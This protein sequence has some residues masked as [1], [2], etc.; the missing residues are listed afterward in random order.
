MS[1]VIKLKGTFDN[2]N[3][4]VL[5]SEGLKSGFYGKYIN[6]LAT[7]DYTLTADQKTAVEAFVDYLA[8]ND[9]FSH[10]QTIFP[11][12]GSSTNVD[13][14]KVPLVGDVELNFADSF[15]SFSFDNDN[16]IVGLT[17][18]PAVTS[19]KLAD[20][21]PK[22]DFLGVAF[23][24]NKIATTESYTDRLMN[25][26]TNFQVR[27]QADK[28]QVYVRTSSGLTTLVGSDAIDGEVKAAAGSF[29]GLLAVGGGKYV[30]YA[31][32]S[33]SVSY[34]GGNYGYTVA[35]TSTD[36]AKSLSSTTSYDV[37]GVFT[38]ITFFKDMITK[39]QAKLYMDGLKAFMTALGRNV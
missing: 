2:P 32:K 24:T 28:I 22:E 37:A 35:K 38:S 7:H 15:D 13:A 10:I 34:S 26:D 11:F 21:Q 39:E 36:L 31:S 25:F 17:G 30:R 29:Y 20:V 18:T 33:T 6:A 16:M 1:T 3:L 27:L 12:I 14:A 9:L 8:A 5:T 19:L 4:P 23:S